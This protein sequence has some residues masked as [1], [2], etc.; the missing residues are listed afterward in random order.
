[1]PK[2][3]EAMAYL[4]STGN[5]YTTALEFFCLIISSIQYGFMVLLFVYVGELFTNMVNNNHNGKAREMYSVCN[6]N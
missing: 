5:S 1:M 3:V 6:C 2:S 4:A